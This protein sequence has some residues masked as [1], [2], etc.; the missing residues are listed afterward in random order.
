M[1][2]CFALSM[3]LA[4]VFMS[5]AGCSAAGNPGSESSTPEEALSQPLS[6]CVGPDPDTIDPAL[7]TAIDGGTLVIHG[8]E[9]LYAL[10]ESG[11]PVPAQAESCDISQDGLTYT[12]HL[13]ENLMWSDGTPLTAEDFV[14]SWQRV[15]DPATAADYSYIFSVI[16]GYSQA[17]GTYDQEGNPVTPPDPSQLAVRALDDRTLEVRL[18]SVT[19]YFLELTAFPIFVPVP[20]HII[21]AQ[22]EAWALSPETYIGNGPY[23]M[24]EWV[25]GSHMT[26]VKNE[27]YWNV[28]A[29]GPDSIRFNLI[30]DD[31][32]QLS[33]FQNGSVA[34][35]D[36]IP[37]AEIDAWQ[38]KPEYHQH[39]ELS[40]YYLSFNV[41]QEPLDDP[42]V[43][44]AL[45]LAIDRE[46]ICTNIGKAG[47]VPAGGF[48]PYGLSDADPSQEFRA[49]GGDY[50]DPSDYEGNLAQARQLLADAG[51]PNGEGLPVIDYM[52]NEGTT[53]QQIAEAL[54][55]M[56]GELGVELNLS[57]QEWRSFI[58]TRK[59]QAYSIACNGWLGDYNDPITFLDMWVTGGGNND[60]GWSNPQYDALIEEVRASSDRTKRME[61]M[62][63]AE[64]LIFADS[65]LCPIYYS[66][67][68]YLQD[69]DLE[70]VWASPLGYKYF[71]YAQFK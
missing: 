12:F 8:F 6:V 63:Q 18:A 58:N 60:A 43:R 1:M 31:V 11:Q 33:A 29:L 27:N 24:T 17:I 10:D 37:N 54:Q 50:Y 51:Y 36:S 15:V 30:E 69:A 66:V 14:W 26:F 25:P 45:T 39:G 61:L 70:G 47:Q 40:T 2:K 9:G 62:H 13:R 16:D 35:I 20:R 44:K 5:L 34:F 48:V 38:D 23:R 71:M 55:S 57:F 22:G 52:Y 7:N 49:V 28:Q 21:E 59:S 32:A 65:M 68:T 46:W 67:D 4:M 56:W 41:N 3:A 64:D 53:N 42:L 19:P